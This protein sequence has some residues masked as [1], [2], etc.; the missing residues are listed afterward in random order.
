[1]GIQIH[2]GDNYRRVLNYPGASHGAVSMHVWVARAWGLQSEA[3]AKKHEDIVF[4][5]DR[6][7]EV[8]LS[9][10]SSIGTW[11]HPHQ[12]TFTTCTC[13]TEMVSLVDL[14]TAM[15]TWAARND[16]RSGP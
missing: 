4:V 12:A 13:Q 3:D 10:K 5:Q 2:A 16:R 15:S 1:M 8:H 7:K 14:A 9:R 6:P 11:L